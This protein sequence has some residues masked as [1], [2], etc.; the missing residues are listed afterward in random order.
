VHAA[1][2]HARRLLQ[3]GEAVLVYP[4]GVREGFKRRGEQYKLFWPQRAELVRMAAKFGA[5]I[6]PVA[7]VG[8]A[9]L[10]CAALAASPCGCAGGQPCQVC[11]GAVHCAAGGGPAIRPLA[12]RGGLPWRS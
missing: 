1:A 10:R 7:S 2:T 9:A 5:I 4:G 8:C 12:G 11:C 3:R 6:V